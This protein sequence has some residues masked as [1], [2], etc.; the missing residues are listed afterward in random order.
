MDRIA[1]FKSFI[2]RNPKD[3]F[4]R[5]GL[6]MEHKTRGEL[7][8]AW[9]AFQDLLSQFADYVPTYL[10]AGGTLTALGRSAEAADIYGRGVTVATQRG[11]SHAR[12]ELETALAELTPSLDSQARP[13]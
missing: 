3:P 6:A 11:D 7:E 12:G 13:Q 8:L 2:D 4:P 10:M 5:Y 9:A 1:T